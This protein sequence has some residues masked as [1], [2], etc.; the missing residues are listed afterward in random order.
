GNRHGEHER[1]DTGEHGRAAVEPRREAEVTG[2][3]K[4][5]RS[6][7][8]AAIDGNPRATLAGTV[9]RCLAVTRG[10]SGGRRVPQTGMLVPQTGMLGLRAAADARSL[11][12]YRSA[13]TGAARAA[14]PAGSLC[15]VEPSSLEGRP[16]SPDV[17]AEP[18]GLSRVRAVNL[19]V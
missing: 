7:F 18:P 8:R 10:R 14:R 11:W 9:T 3:H 19:R 15:D 2:E 16:P 17:S 13:S 1:R 12:A 4:S 5:T 6:G